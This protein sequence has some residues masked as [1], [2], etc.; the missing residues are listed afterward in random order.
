M[1]DVGFHC[2]LLLIL[3]PL[4]KLDTAPGLHLNNEK[5]CL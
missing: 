1:I 5:N 4:Q 3:R 2:L